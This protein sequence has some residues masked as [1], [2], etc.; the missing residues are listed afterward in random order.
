MVL[1]FECV[2]EILCDHSNETSL[3]VLLYGTICFS[4]FYKIKLGFFLNFVIW[5]SW[6]LLKNLSKF[7]SQR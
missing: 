1:A 4:I 7:H 6:A 2:N 3:V 5:H